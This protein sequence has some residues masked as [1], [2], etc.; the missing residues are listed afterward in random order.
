[1]QLLVVQM[2]LGRTCIYVSLPQSLGAQIHIAMKQVETKNK[3]R[4]IYIDDYI[5]ILYVATVYTWIRFR[6]AV[7]G[8]L[9]PFEDAY[10]DFM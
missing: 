5:C 8:N 2:L 1:M 3:L 9:I 7:S 10:V 6:D 4:Y